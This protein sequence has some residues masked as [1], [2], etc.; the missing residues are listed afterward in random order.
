MNSLRTATVPAARRDS[1]AQ[2]HSSRSLGHV[3]THRSEEF[4]I[5]PNE[6]S[7]AALRAACQATGGLVRGDD[8]AR[9]LWDRQRSD[10]VSLARLIASGEV[11]SFRWH[12]SLWMPMFQFEPGELTIKPAPRQVL[13]EFGNVFDGWSVAVWFVQPCS[14]LDDRRPVDLLDGDLA[15]VLDAARA[16]RFIATG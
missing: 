16:D 12:G 14:W 5:R 7:F 10:Y 1:D 15:A 2:A 9:T 3:P 13:G 8:L 4:G 11:L 6:H